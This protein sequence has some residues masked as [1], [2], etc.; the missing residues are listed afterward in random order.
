MYEVSD[1]WVADNELHYISNGSGENA[2]KLDQVDLQRTADENTKR[3]TQ[4]TLKT[5]RPAP[6]TRA[7]QIREDPTNSASPGTKQNNGGDA[8][9]PAKP[10]AQPPIKTTSQTDNQPQ[11]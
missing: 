4:F 2:V 8:T 3:G 11:G 1:Y 10:P 7:D 5:N 6:A 9:P